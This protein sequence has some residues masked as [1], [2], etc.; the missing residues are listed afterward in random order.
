MQSLME[1]HTLTRKMVCISTKVGSFD[2]ISWASISNE[3]YA[4]GE[5]KKTCMA[6]LNL[7][8]VCCRHIFVANV[9]FT[10]AV[11]AN[12][13]AA[14][15]GVIFQLILNECYSSY[16]AVSSIVTIHNSGFGP[17]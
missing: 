3:N 16:E 13:F 7:V 11:N 17:I 4:Y 1:L 14:Q 9:F 8:V 2:G 5:E 15:N 10:S 12:A 6:I